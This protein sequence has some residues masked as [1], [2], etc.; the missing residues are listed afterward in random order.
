MTVVDAAA[1]R[2]R[3]ADDLVA[4][5]HAAGIRVMVDLVPN[6]SSNRHRWFRAALAGGPDAPERAL[7]HVR[8]GRGERAERFDRTR[9]E[10]SVR[11]S[12]REDRISVGTGGRRRSSGHPC[13]Y[14][15]STRRPRGRSSPRRP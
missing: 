2:R 15:I 6:H 13:R 9:D 12:S 10:R 5:L 1:L 7:Y 14:A 8:E 4:A 11:T 3:A